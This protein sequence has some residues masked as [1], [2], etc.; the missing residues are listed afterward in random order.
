MNALF[1]FQHD[2]PHDSVLELA[3][4][5]L[6]HLPQNDRLCLW[7]GTSSEFVLTVYSAVVK[8][9]SRL[10]PSCPSVPVSLCFPL[11]G[12]QGEAGQ[13]QRLLA[14]LCELGRFKGCEQDKNK[15][16]RPSHVTGSGTFSFV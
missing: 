12:V 5:S 7:A 4:S 10:A 9:C 2:G 15:R 1:Q 6:L 11:P 14:L 8:C 3:L 16:R 13:H